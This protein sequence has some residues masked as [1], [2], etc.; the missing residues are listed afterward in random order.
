MILSTKELS[1]SEPVVQEYRMQRNEPL[2]FGGP[3]IINWNEATTKNKVF[4][5]ELFRGGEYSPMANLSV[6]V[7]PAE[8]EFFCQVGGYGESRRTI[9]SITPSGIPIIGGGPT[10]TYTVN[11]YF[12]T[13]LD[14]ETL[15]YSGTDTSTT[16]YGKVDRYRKI[17]RNRICLET[18]ARWKDKFIHGYY[19]TQLRSYFLD[20]Y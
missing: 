15:A 16:T 19:D 20:A 7:N 1:E 3:E 10:Y 8:D 17:M 2:T 6:S 14:Q 13:V 12:N 4:F 9:D 11:T 18:M 5:R